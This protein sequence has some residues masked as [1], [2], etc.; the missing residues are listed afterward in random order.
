MAIVVG[1]TTR[2][3]VREACKLFLIDTVALA[4][5]ELMTPLRSGTESDDVLVRCV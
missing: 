5:T 2:Y 1:K 4:V 3:I